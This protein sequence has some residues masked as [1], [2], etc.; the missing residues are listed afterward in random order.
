[1]RYFPDIKDGI[2]LDNSSTATT[3]LVRANDAK[4][5]RNLRAYYKHLDKISGR[6][7]KNVYQFFRFGFAE[8]SLHDGLLVSLSIGDAIGYDDSRI[9]L[10]PFSRFGHG[11]GAV[12]IRIANYERDSLHTFN[13]SGIKSLSVD[14]PTA[15]PLWFTP[16]RSLGTIYTYEIFAA[17]SRYLRCE[18]L[19]DSGG[20]IVVLFERLK[21]KRRRLAK[22]Q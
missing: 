20:T 4:Y 18:W 11:R 17:S 9:V 3:A 13:F 22:Q 1:M 2:K 16:G 7:E 6:L 19:L 12:E 15:D 14:I 8:K 5:L 10:S 21:Y